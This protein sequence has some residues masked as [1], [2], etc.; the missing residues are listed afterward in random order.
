MD[1]ISSEEAAKILGVT[2]NYLHH[3]SRDGYL[4]SHLVGQSYL[5]DPNEVHELKE[6]RKNGITLAEVAARASR[7]EMIAYRLERQMSRLLNIIGADIPS[8]DLRP[9]AVVALHLKIEDASTCTR[10]PSIEELLEW[11]HI[12]QSLNEQYFHEIEREFLTDEPWKLYIK[13]SNNLAKN[14]PF[15][16]LRN[17]LELTTAYNYLEM[18]RK[19]LRQVIFCYVRTTSNKRIAY[20]VIPEAAND[21][22]EDVMSLLSV[23]VD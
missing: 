20:R 8:V 19:H 15:D 10:I 2:K 12:F 6:V 4:R 17:D 16:K 7:A 22:H 18:S 1:L 14:M 21:F 11:A 13:L 9:E 5:Y 3:M 23:I